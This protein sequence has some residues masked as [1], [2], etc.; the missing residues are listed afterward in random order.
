MGSLQEVTISNFFGETNPEFL[1]HNQDG[2]KKKPR[3]K[4][5]LKK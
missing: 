1:F 3:E 5:S 4:G 2:I